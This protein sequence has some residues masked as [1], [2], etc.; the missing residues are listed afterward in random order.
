MVEELVRQLEE[1]GI[2]VRHEPDDTHGFAPPGDPH[3]WLLSLVADFPDPDGYFRGLVAGGERGLALDDEAASLLTRARALQKQDARLEVFRELD[4][5][6]V[7]ERVV[8]VPIGY[9]RR[10]LLRRPWLHGSWSNA[11][12]S[13]ELGEARI[14]RPRRTS[15]QR[16]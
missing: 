10:I 9:P 8:G 13:I 15:E 2:R 16:R 11:L 1:V 12:S 6:L 5:H 14:E 3:M 4:R 7:T